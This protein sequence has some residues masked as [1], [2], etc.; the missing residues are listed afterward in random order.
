MQVPLAAL[1]CGQREGPGIAAGI[2]SPAFFRPA[3]AHLSLHPV[4]TDAFGR[5]A[6]YVPTHPGAIILSVLHASYL[7]QC[8]FPI[9]M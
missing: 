1:I 7:P 4:P 6:A 2:F 9:S 8:E 3:P 5:Q